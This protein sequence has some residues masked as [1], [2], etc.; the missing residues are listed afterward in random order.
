MLAVGTSRFTRMLV[1]VGIFV[2]TV[3]AVMLGVQDLFAQSE[4]RLAY[5]MLAT[6]CA[7]GV[8]GLG[9][10]LTS[11]DLAA[12]FVA[13]LPIVALAT[14]AGGYFKDAELS[15]FLRDQPPWFSRCWSA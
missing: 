13:A 6:A 7:L 14:D 1:V 5:A 3:F 8:V 10:R 4:A 11:L 15:L 9:L 12:I 2:T